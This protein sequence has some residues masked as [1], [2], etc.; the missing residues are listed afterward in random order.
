VPLNLGQLYD[1]H[2]A[3]LFAFVLDLTRSETDTRDVLQDVFCR[4]AARP[5][6][7]DAARDVRAF[8]LRLAHNLA[9]DLIRRGAARN[10]AREALAAQPIDLF[11]PAADPD[12]A[13]LRREI[14]AALAELPPEQRA[15]V[16]LKLWD[17]LTFDAI[18]EA[19]G[20]PLNTAASRYR[21]ALDKLRARLR[22]LYEE[23]R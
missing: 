12:A 6:L 18:G 17:D 21:Y 10:R 9:V 23:I 5:E 4:L 11:T 3:A 19:L 8:L 1:A 7:L 16:H 2:A 13:A 20:I 14:E 22:P 15:V